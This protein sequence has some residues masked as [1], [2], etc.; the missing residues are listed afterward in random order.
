MTKKE[1]KKFINTLPENI[2][3][4]DFRSVVSDKI[5][6]LVRPKEYY[7]QLYGV[8]KDIIRNRLVNTS[9]NLS[10]NL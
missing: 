3:Y 10:N 6:P 4:T 9:Y 1:I 8:F 2:S 7:Y 5:R